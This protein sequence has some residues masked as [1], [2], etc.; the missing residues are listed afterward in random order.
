MKTEVFTR[1]DNTEG[2]NYIPESGDKVMA[3]F[4]DVRISKSGA[5]ENYSL[6]VKTLDQKPK[7]VYIKLTGGQYRNLQSCTDLTDKTLEFV[8]YENDFGK[9]VGV[10][11]LFGDKV[12][13]EDFVSADKTK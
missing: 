4:K 12:S 8:E 3:K 2:V 5:Y 1:K 11:V 13:K 9:Q 6:G 7:E 10:R